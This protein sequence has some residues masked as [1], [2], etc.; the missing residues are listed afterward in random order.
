MIL[1][2]IVLWRFFLETATFVLPMPRKSEI[3]GVVI[4][5]FD[6]SAK[7]GTSNAGESKQVPLENPTPEPPTSLAL[8]N[9]KAPVLEDPRPPVLED[10]RP[11]V[12]E[13]PKA[14]VLEDSRPPVGENPKAAVLEDPRPPVLEDLRPF[15]EDPKP[16]MPQQV[17]E[18]PLPEVPSDPPAGLL[19]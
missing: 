3:E 16:K 14:A 13:N 9:P 18:H 15:L 11:P 7:D 12:D 8:E 17:P 1:F 2:D 5:A 19:Y 4:E 6:N 10:P